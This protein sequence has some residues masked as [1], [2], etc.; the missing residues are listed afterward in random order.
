MQTS[1][2][3]PG[4]VSEPNT[5]DGLVNMIS[6]GMYCLRPIVVITMLIIFCAVLCPIAGT[7]RER[8]RSSASLARSSLHTSSHSSTQGS[9]ALEPQDFKLYIFLES[10]PRVSPGGVQA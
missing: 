5:S 10:H 8:N 1:T 9:L 2:M 7:G 4:R 6:C 3:V